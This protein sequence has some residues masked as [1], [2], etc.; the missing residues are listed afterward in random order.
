MR[1]V[2][3]D[4]PM[5]IKAVI[6]AVTSGIPWWNTNIT[7]NGSSGSGCSAL[8]NRNGTYLQ[9]TRNCSLTQ[10]YLICEFSNSERKSPGQFR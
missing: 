9:T 7:V 8:N 2:R 1:L 3:L 10:T 4:S 6:D 5:V